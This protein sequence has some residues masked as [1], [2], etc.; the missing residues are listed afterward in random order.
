MRLSLLKI[1]KVILSLFVVSVLCTRCIKIPYEETTISL[2]VS[3]SS[4]NF[5]SSGASQSFTVSS[6]EYWY[7]ESYKFK[8]PSWLSI[9]PTYGYNSAKITMVADRNTT[10][11][12]RNETI[13]IRSGVSG[14]NDQSISVTQAG[15]TTLSVSP[16]SLS[17][18]YSGE[19]KTF[20]VSSNN[21]WSIS[22][23]H[24]WLTV[25]PMTGNGNRTVTV[26]AGRNTS[27]S[28]RNATITV[29]SDVSGVSAQNITMT[30]AGAPT[31]AQIRFRKDGA[32]SDRTQL[33][34]RNSSGTL[35]ASYNFGSSAGTS[36]YYSVTA[37]TYYPVV[38][39]SSDGWVYF[40]FSDG[41]LASH[42]LSA[43]YRYTYRLYRNNSGGYTGTLEN[44]GTF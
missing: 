35:V 26:T 11:V 40:Y 6:N 8:L 29:R 14:V 13:T 12:S 7:I 28:S 39:R 33:G 5:P 1:G 19:S 17:F 31:T 21:G 15:A 3:P 32:Y 42:N 4:L 43:G 23:A 41:S 30:Q 18:T 9:T 44:D 16:S 24:S 38:Y 2:S 37:G 20:T 34:I 27:S 25:S 36:S 22:G 10:S